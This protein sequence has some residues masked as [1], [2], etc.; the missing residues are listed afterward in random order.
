[1]TVHNGTLLLKYKNQRAGLGIQAGN[2]SSSGYGRSST[3][4]SLG[5]RQP[6]LDRSS[7]D[8]LPASRS[9]QCLFCVLIMY[10]FFKF[11][12]IFSVFVISGNLAVAAGRVQT[13]W[14]WLLQCFKQLILAI[15]T[16]ELVHPQR[17]L[18]IIGQRPCTA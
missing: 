18:L 11:G 14:G 9:G 1:M 10:E 8:R 17:G 2:G 3:G 5:E 15:T 12:K 6:Q 13:Q 4:M 7:L 16:G